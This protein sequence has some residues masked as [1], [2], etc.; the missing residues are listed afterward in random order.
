MPPVQVSNKQTENPYDFIVNEAPKPQ[1][2]SLLSNQ[3]SFKQRLIV[4]LGGGIVL[5]I[6][7]IIIASI[8]S[9]K[10]KTAGLLSIAQQQ[11]TLITLAYLG[12]KTAA[13]QITKDLATNVSLSLTSGRLSLVTYL[14]ATGS[15]LTSASLLTTQSIT[16]ST[17]LTATPANNFDSEYVQLTQTQLINYVSALKQVFSS[18]DP[19]SQKII[20]SN[21]YAGAILLLKQANSAAADL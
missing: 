21:L 12:E 2:P 3:T 4:I 9:P 18:S 10:P 7:I 8:L 5:I 6:V 13:Q 17:E 1:K 19:A 14:E 20:I 11:S 16:L 15:K